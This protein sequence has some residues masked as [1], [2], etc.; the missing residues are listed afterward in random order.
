MLKLADGRDTA[1]SH[2][3]CYSRTGLA[4]STVPLRLAY[5]A[6]IKIILPDY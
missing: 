3:G 5:A 6:I 4:P 2:Q 1:S